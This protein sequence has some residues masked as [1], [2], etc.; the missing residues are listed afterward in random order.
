M[1]I[2]NAAL[3]VVSCTACSTFKTMAP[4]NGQINISHDGYDS[5][6][7]KIPRVYSGVAYN[8]CRL[9]SEPNT[10]GYDGLAGFGVP[11]IFLDTVCSAV[12]DTVALPYTIYTQVNNGNIKVN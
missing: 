9:N 11:I 8:F 2:F 6:C 1:K 10:S 5:K 12:A 4:T 3:L 7:N